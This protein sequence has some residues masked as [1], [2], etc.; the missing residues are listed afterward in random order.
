MASFIKRLNIAH[1]NCRRAR[2]SLFVPG[3]WDNKSGVSVSKAEPMWN[4]EWETY[5]E[6]LQTITGSLVH[7]INSMQ[8]VLKPRRFCHTEPIKTSQATFQQLEMNSYLPTR[9]CGKEIQGKGKSNNLYQNQSCG[10]LRYW[11]LS[12]SEAECTLRTVGRLHIV[13]LWLG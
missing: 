2:S 13:H 5:G 11:S 4:L 7:L 12:S 6:P 1:N 9:K 3:R 10:I 8:S